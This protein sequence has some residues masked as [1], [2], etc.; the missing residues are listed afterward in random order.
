MT[1][2]RSEAQ[3][4]LDELSK[5][6]EKRAHAKYRLLAGA[7]KPAALNEQPRTSESGHE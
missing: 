6:S 1:N 5:A 2:S 3:V 7:A 4:L